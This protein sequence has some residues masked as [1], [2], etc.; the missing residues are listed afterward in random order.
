V[1][2]VERTIGGVDATRD[3]LLPFVGP[4]AALPLWSVLARLPVDASRVVWIAMLMAAIA[5]LATASAALALGR[6]TIA[7]VFDVLLVAGL[8]GP[9]I[10]DVALGQ[11]A[12]LSAAAVALALIALGR[13]S[14]WAVPAAFVA[15][16]QPNLALPL[17]VRLIEK[18]S[19]LLLAL[20]V[21]LFLAVTLAA[22]GGVAGIF[23]YVHRLG[24]HSAGE[25]FIL[26][27]YSVAAIAAS[28]QTPAVTAI[29]AGNVCA[30]VAVGIVF[31]ATL[32]YSAQPRMT[33][34]IAIALVPWIVPFFHEHD[35]VLELI[36]V[37]IL[38]LCPVARVRTVALIGSVCVLVD[39]LGIAQRPNV[40]MQTLVIAIGV[41]CAIA[42]LPRTAG[43][44]VL[45]LPA[46]GTVAVLIA[47]AVPLALSH[48]APVWPDTL[49]NFHAAPD[50]DASAVWA[51]EQQASGL[52]EF[53]PAWAVLRAIPMTGCLLLALAGILAARDG[54][55]QAL[56]GYATT[57][58]PPR[59]AR[60]TAVSDSPSHGPSV[61]KPSAKRNDA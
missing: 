31:V 28:L 46:L 49:G 15:A 51:A 48:P 26:I 7:G 13:G 59:T 43:L 41:A 20:A 18:R 53:V 47:I 9:F 6:V 35:F 54:R 25:R 1:W 32:R 4:A 45:P 29:A 14:W 39:W 55:R 33:A 23:D 5:V 27:Q 50:L 2:N 8:S 60:R 17:A 24:M 12:L 57:T 58:R 38:A 16:I 40:A 36:P 11:V 19:V 3:E 52:G 34:A 30:I 10:S 42:A 44:R 37:T 22:G 61:Q 56:A 21:T